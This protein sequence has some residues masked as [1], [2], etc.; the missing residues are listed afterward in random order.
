MPQR[1]SVTDRDDQLTNPSLPIESSAAA[2]FEV[3]PVDAARPMG[4]QNE[5]VAV[6]LVRPLSLRCPCLD[7]TKRHSLD[8]ICREEACRIVRRSSRARQGG[9]MP[10]R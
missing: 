8:V 2:T 4:R 5:E 7:E 6:K 1:A 10:C 3:D 9:S